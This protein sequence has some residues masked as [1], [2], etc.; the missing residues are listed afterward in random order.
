MSGVSPINAGN[1]EPK[2]PV[3]TPV[4]SA[5]PIKQQS[6]AAA[7]KEEG[8]STTAK[9][10]GGA[11]LVGI[12]ATAAYFLTKGKNKAAL[13]EATKKADEAKKALDE[14]KA[15]MPDGA[16][17]TTQAVAEAGTKAPEAT[18][19][20]TST[21]T[22]ATKDGV[23]TY[24]YSNGRV[25]THKT[26]KGKAVII[27]EK[28]GNSIIYNFKNTNKTAS[29]LST[30]T[31]TL[32]N[33]NEHGFNELVFNADGVLKS[34]K[35]P[36]GAKLELTSTP[37]VY[38]RGG[39]RKDIYMPK[40]YFAKGE[41][42]IIEGGTE[43][44]YSLA[45]KKATGKVIETSANKTTVK[46]NK[47]L[48]SET[49]TRKNG[50]T[51]TE[52][53]NGKKSVEK[54]IDNKGNVLKETTFN[55]DAKPMKIVEKN[56]DGTIRKVTEHTYAEQKWSKTVVKDGEGKLIS[57]V[58]R[59]TNGTYKIEKPDMKVIAK[60][61]NGSNILKGIVW[62]NSEKKVVQEAYVP[63]QGGSVEILI[64]SGKKYTI[65]GKIQK[66]D[67]ANKFIE[68]AKVE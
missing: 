43:T 25:V 41:Y 6:F 15:K 36:K 52:F 5:T 2:T 21:V 11:V 1:V 47:Q 53:A 42:S 12:G 27:D 64:Q 24:T 20:I 28:D 55:T 66:P 46:V 34:A 49:V 9:M 3:K 18:A 19:P 63:T 10:I 44:M 17:K 67:K 16:N 57:S 29:D 35:G 4:K 58:E 61:K 48:V 14:L 13:E 33:P 37:D 23:T 32:K 68:S 50:S 7:E 38:S 8:M 56:A 40:E 45:T 39:N 30:K 26:E 51:I 62:T 60:D 59:L 22:K 31:I 65:D 54:S